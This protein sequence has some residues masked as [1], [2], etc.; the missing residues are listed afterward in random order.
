VRAVDPVDVLQLGQIGARRRSPDV[1]AIAME[2]RVALARDASADA[3]AVAR[4]P[5]LPI[6]AVARSC[7]PSR[8]AR[9]QRQRADHR[10]TDFEVR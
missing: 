3:L 8:P 9:E 1:A 4:A 5:A 7:G 6:D 10:C 2:E